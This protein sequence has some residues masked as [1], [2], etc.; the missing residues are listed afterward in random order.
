MPAI[1]EAIRRGAIRIL[2]VAALTNTPL[3]EGERCALS[4]AVSRKIPLVCDDGK[5]RSVGRALGVSVL[6][7]TALLIWAAESVILPPKEAIE[8]LDEL[9][10]AGYHISP[11]VYVAVKDAIRKV[12]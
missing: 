9:V 7:L 2:P 8:T 1:K 4:L 5:A 6:P 11:A 3:D 12:P 10:R